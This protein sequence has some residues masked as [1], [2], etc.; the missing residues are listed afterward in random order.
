M[1]LSEHGFTVFAGVRKASDAEALREDT[2]GRA[3]PLIFD[4]TDPAAVTAAAA[5]VA[6]ATGGR[7]IAGLVNNAGVFVLGPVEQASMEEIDQQFRVNLIGALVVTQRFLPALRRGRGRIVNV[8]SLNGR[9]AIPFAGIYSAT[10]FALEAVSD[11][12][13]VELRGSGVSVSVVQPGMTGT[14][15]RHSAMEA[16]T[17]RRARL[18][19]E[20]RELYEERFQKLSSIIESLDAGAAGHEH[21]SRDVLHALTA[22]RPKTRYRT[23]PDWEQWSG[24]LGLS[25]EERD[26]AF[27]EML[28]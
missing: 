13:R 1:D 6:G 19:G 20:E 11:A 27:A 17:A 14:G 16:W 18:S 22:E 12:L 15:L 8:S 26:R 4:V 28:Q 5:E 2:G 10:K 24:M 9:I 21:V 3:L 23:G 25:D 7:G